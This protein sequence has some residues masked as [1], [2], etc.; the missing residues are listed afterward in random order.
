MSEKSEQNAP[1]RCSCCTCGYTWAKG[2]YGGHSCA[3]VMEVTVAD[4]R[5]R[6]AKY[7][8]AD[9]N[10]AS[11]ITEQAR[12]IS[13]LR[14]IISECATAC[15]AAVSVECSLEFMALLPKEIALKAKPISVVDSQR[16]LD[17]N[18]SQPE[19]RPIVVGR[20]Y[21]VAE[22]CARFNSSPASAGDDRKLSDIGNE[23]HNLSCHVVH[24]NE[25][26]ANQLGTLASE[27]WNWQARATLSAP[28]HGD[29]V[30]GLGHDGW[31]QA[32]DNV[33]AYAHL[34]NSGFGIIHE[35]RAEYARLIATTPSAGSQ[36][37]GE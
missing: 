23:L 31:R 16:L 14:N 6:L 21:Q 26:W 2:Q 37:Q 7:E 10:P 32:V 34:Y 30:R 36:E 27:L 19:P 28:S 11:T 24:H 3:Q 12:E 1:E 35:I 8:D 15:G 9:G 13:S 5:A 17:W 20:E 29:L 22:A 25:G 4:L 18:R 33:S